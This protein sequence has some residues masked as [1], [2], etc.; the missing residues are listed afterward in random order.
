MPIYFKYIF[1]MTVQKVFDF[2][3]ASYLYNYSFMYIGNKVI[4]F[5]RQIGGA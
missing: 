2:F 4:S 3:Y 5:I 1:E